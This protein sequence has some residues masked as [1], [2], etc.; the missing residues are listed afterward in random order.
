M[1]PPPA[2]ES[3]PLP[4]EPSRGW[5]E[6]LRNGR[7]WLAAGTRRRRALRELARFAREGRWP[8]RRGRPDILLL[9]TASGPA[10]SWAGPGEWPALAARLFRLDPA[11]VAAGAPLVHRPEPDGSVRLAG[12]APGSAPASRLPL[13][14]LA[15]AIEDSLSDSERADLLLLAADPSA[16]ATAEAAELA[17]LLGART[18]PFPSPFDAPTLRSRLDGAFPRVS[19]LVVAHNGKGFT[20]PCLLSL[21]EGESWPSLEVVVVDNGSTDGTSGFLAG[22]RDPRLRVVPLP[23]NRGFA[24]GNNAGLAACTGRFVVLLNNDTVVPPG[25]IG[26]LLPHLEV[27]P[28]LGLVGP[29]TNEC[30]NEARLEAGYRRF[31][32]LPAFAARRARAHRGSRRSLA[33]AAMFCVAA[34]R[35]LFDRV[36]LLDENFGIGLF[37]DDDYSLRVRAA[38]FEVALADD[39]YVHHVGGGAMSALR[40]AEFSRLWERNRSYFEAKWGHPWV[41]H[42]SA[43][44]GTG[45]GPERG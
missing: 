29:R 30:G 25:L 15:D 8:A 17:R 32:D 40:R 28:A 45:P 39:A 1:T 13:P 4:G 14:A 5:R 16:G 35:E 19:V 7:R 26:R 34:R 24:A 3:P 31:E 23:E 27:D 10:P 18:A 11:T 43:P 38:G 21:L 44:P 6:A 33:M 42:R 41:P 9:G 37:E 22:L 2:G 36:G 12:A 20:E